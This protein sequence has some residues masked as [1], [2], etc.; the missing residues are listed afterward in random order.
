MSHL[1]LVTISPSSSDR[2]EPIGSLLRSAR[3][4]RG[5][6]QYGLAAALAAMSGNDG[7]D[8]ESVA[9]WERGGRIPGPYWRRWLAAAL[10]LSEAQ[11]RIAARR[12]R[13]L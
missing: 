5:L 7:I 3:R 4:A 8:R 12:D 2:R 9:R 1:G 10:D 6:S 13:A 11:L